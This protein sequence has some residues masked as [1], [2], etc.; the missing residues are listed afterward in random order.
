LQISNRQ[1]AI[2][3]SASVGIRT[4]IKQQVRDIIGS[5]ATIVHFTEEEARNTNFDK[6]YV[7]FSTIPL[8]NNLKRTVVIRVTNLFNG[9]FLKSEW[10]KLSKGNSINF[11][12]QLFFFRKIDDSLDYHQNLNQMMVTLSQKG[13]IDSQFE[14]RMSERET[15]TNG[16]YQ[17][18]VAFPHTVNLNS[19]RIIV[20]VA[21][22]QIPIQLRDASIQIIIL[23]A[24]PETMS[25]EVETELLAL[26]DFIFRI[27]GRASIKQKLLQIKSVQELS[28]YFQV[29]G[30]F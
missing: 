16:F 30:V 4:L 12:R 23:L 13:L 22:S 25:D 3:S 11:S 5:D 19:D 15:L 18:G 29:G 28:R 2:V 26:Y 20:S 27:M 6:Y 24:I 10:M 7:V 1:V 17:N 9:N 8:D 21:I 14:Q